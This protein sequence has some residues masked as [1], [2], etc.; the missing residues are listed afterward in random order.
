[1]TY[2]YDG[3]TGGNDA[4]SATADAAFAGWATSASGGAVYTDG[5]E[6]SNL[7]AEADAT[8]SLYAVWTDGS[9]TLP[10]PVKRD[11]AFDGWYGSEALTARVGAG[12]AS[13]TPEQDIILYAKWT[14]L[15]KVLTP[16]FSL[17]GGSYVGAQSV[18][19]TC[20]TEGAAIWYTTDGSEPTT[21]GT[22][23]A[24]AIEVPIG[25]TTLKAI[26]VKE[27]M[28]DS[29]AA[30]AAYTVTAASFALTVTAPEFDAVNV[31]YAQPEARA[32]TLASTGN[33]A[34]TVSSVALSGANADSFVL[35]RTDGTTVAAGAT[36]AATYTVRPAAG[37]AAGTY[38]ATVTAAYD[39]GVTASAELRF[40]VNAVSAGVT[41]TLENGNLTIA[42]SGAM[43]DYSPGG[44]PWFARRAEIEY[45]SIGPDV[46]HVGAYAFYACGAIHCADIQG[47]GVSVGNRAFAYCCSLGEFGA[48]SGLT[49]V[50]E[51][52]F[53]ACFRLTDRGF[54]GGAAVGDKAFEL[55]GLGG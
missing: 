25:T 34:V 18:T 43:E 44:A 41:W 49:S 12:G 46:T 35:N 40:T 10:T 21:G 33:S 51:G 32:L 30:T 8:V 27:G 3:A 15:D 17:A 23:Y 45:V 7:T 39:G 52:A 11:Y 2:A 50:G 55:C 9:V 47:S 54:A 6:L 36:D 26:A 28:R 53:Y 48:G 13:Y 29:D 19:I 1:V 20:A 14:E 5:Q 31:G 22:L 38:T 42:G 37:L 16:A 24:G 4:A